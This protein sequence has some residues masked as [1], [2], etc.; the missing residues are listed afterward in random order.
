MDETVTFI[1]TDREDSGFVESIYAMRNIMDYGNGIVLHEAE[2]L[3]NILN[4]VKK[5]FEFR[6]LI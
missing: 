6:V 2:Y 4:H 1:I 3:K 5:D